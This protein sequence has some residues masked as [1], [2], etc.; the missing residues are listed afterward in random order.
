MA[1]SASGIHTAC[2][3]ESPAWSRHIAGFEGEWSFG[4][5]EA[6]GRVKMEC[7]TWWYLRPLEG[8]FGFY[9]RDLPVNPQ[10]GLLNP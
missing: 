9:L 2:L 8:P 1:A 10:I 7:S 4:S 5:L 3:S 6:A